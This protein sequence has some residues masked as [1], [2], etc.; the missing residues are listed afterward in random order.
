[1]STTT[2]YNLALSLVS[3]VK[4]VP[5]ETEQ[6]VTFNANVK[7]PTLSSEEH[8][9]RK[10]VNLVAVID[11]SGSMSGEPLRLVREALDFVVTQLKDGDH[12]A[13]VTFGDHAKLLLPLLNMDDAGKTQATRIISGL[14]TDG[15]TNMSAGITMGF[16]QLCSLY[17]IASP[18]HPTSETSGSRS[19]L[20]YG[21]VMSRRAPQ[22]AQQPIQQTQTT[23][24]Q[25]TLS[26]VTISPPAEA[27]T[28]PAPS[29]STQTTTALASSVTSVLLLSDGQA[30]RGIS[31]TDALVAHVSQSFAPIAE[32]AAKANG[33]ATLHTF[34]FSEGHNPELMTR[35]AEA[36]NGV[37]YYVP[38]GDR[39][40]DVFADCLGGL[41]SVAALNVELEID[42][43]AT[44]ATLGQIQTPFAISTLEANKRVKVALG[45]L[46]SEQSCDI[47]IEVKL[48]A[49]PGTDLDVKVLQATLTSL[50]R[51]EQ[52]S[53]SQAI[54][55]I[56]RVAAADPVIASQEP[57][58]VVVDQKARYA[59]ATALKEAIALKSQGRTAEAHSRLSKAKAD[60]SGYSGYAQQ[61][62]TASNELSSANQGYL[63][64]QMRSNFAQAS[65]AQAPVSDDAECEE[66][67]S[68]T[69]SNAMK[70]QMVSKMRSHQQR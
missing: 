34:G 20:A 36:G 53:T 22:V 24:L 30:N 2:D 51:K 70:K 47:L 7:A 64:G 61:L 46:Y 54:V 67:N 29:T 39:I 28:K 25:Q 49:I 19:A 37:F 23:H 31:G 1:M 41:L 35:M 26:A 52:P 62:E 55:T 58:K 12:L 65:S 9:Q 14:N 68:A 21:N 27:E 57:N 50:N 11:V 48:P 5:F 18:Q 32:A 44:G 56:D 6:T 17:G 69:Y 60:V 40:G 63:W 43:Q 59:T 16:S 13:L 15:M 38:T 10:N 3:E 8:E 42:V 45:Q 33:A 66:A 4:S